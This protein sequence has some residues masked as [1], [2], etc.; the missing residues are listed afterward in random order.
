[1]EIKLNGELKQIE[2]EM[3]IEQLLDSLKIDKRHL[4]VEYN[5]DFLEEADLGAMRVKDGDTL[6]IVRFVGGG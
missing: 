4:A 2:G 1:M 5:G 6:E 3:S